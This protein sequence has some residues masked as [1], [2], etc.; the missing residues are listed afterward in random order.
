MELN[1]AVGAESLQLRSV[2]IAIATHLLTILDLDFETVLGHTV[3]I[4]GP[5]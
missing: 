3:Y 1:S 5:H 4:T 2:D